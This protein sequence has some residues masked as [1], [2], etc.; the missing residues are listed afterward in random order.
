MLSG[1][2]RLDKRHDCRKPITSDILISLLDALKFVCYSVYETCLFKVSFLVAFLEFLRVGEIAKSNFYENHNVKRS[3][4]T[5]DSNSGSLNITIPSCKTD[6]LGNSVTFVLE[7]NKSCSV[8]PVQLMSDYFAMRHKNDGHLFCHANEKTLRI[9]VAT[10]SFL[11]GLDENSIKMKGRWKAA[12]KGKYRNKP[13]IVFKNLISGYLKDIWVIGSSIVTRASD[14]AQIMPVGAS[15]RL[16]KIGCQLVWIAK[17]NSNTKCNVQNSIVDCSH[18]VLTAI[19]R[20]LPV[21]ATSLDLRHGFVK[22]AGANSFLSKNLRLQDINLSSNRI[23]SIPNGLFLHPFKQLLLVNMSH[24]YLTIF[25]EFHASIKALNIIDLTFNSITHFNNEDIEQIEKLGEVNILLGGNPFQ[26]SCKTLQFL[27]WLGQTNRVLD[28]L[29]LTCVTEKASRRFISEVISNMKTFEISC[30][31]KFW[32]PFAVS[33]TSIIV[34][35]IITTVIFFR[36][37]YAVEY[38]LL[39]LKMK[40]KNYKELQQEY[41]Y[42]AFISYSHTDAEWVKQFYDKVNSMGFE[43]C[44]DAKDFIA[45]NSI[46]ENV[47]NAIDSSRKVIFILTRNFL[48]SNWGSYEMEMTRMHAF[49]KGREDMVIIVVKDQ[50]E[51]DEMP[52]VMKEMWFKIICIKW[53]NDDNLPYNTE[54][55]FYDK[56][57]ISLKRKEQTTRK[58]VV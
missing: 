49:Q 9:G 42:D 12:Y 51:V 34:M 48:K 32:L 7:R 41:T 27:K 18:L 47:I 28:I 15:L 10:Q 16:E 4:I 39:R 37:K 1:M 55:I 11:D 17:G 23:N 56:M 31:T 29:D 38:F 25:P 6:Q 20:H 8:C 57:K 13:R 19:P 45:G 54:D 21:N 50:I 5:I 53:P 22:T 33:I 24:N 58:L 36:Y 14:H 52:D 2:L 43:L 26:C 40:M 46:A 3:N 44:L 30:K 35:A